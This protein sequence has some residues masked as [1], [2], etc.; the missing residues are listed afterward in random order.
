MST[1]INNSGIESQ[2]S[3]YNELLLQRNNHLAVSSEQNPLVMDIDQ[4]LATMKNSILGAIDNELT[5]LNTRRQTAGAMQS[6]AAGKPA[7]NP[8]QARHLLSFERQQKV[9][10]SLYLFLLQ[11][12]EENELSQAFTAYNTRVIEHPTSS[13]DPVSPNYP[14]VIIIALI[15]ALA[16]PAS[17]ITV[18]EGFNTTVRGRKD[19]ECINAP[20]SERYPSP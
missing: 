1:G 4:K 12:R 6:Q 2:V 15:A 19:L 10:E 17:I 13:P 7:A 20:L 8:E 5:M 18:K 14:S 11:K 16:I 9:K 3:A